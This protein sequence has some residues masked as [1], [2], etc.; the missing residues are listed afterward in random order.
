MTEVSELTPTDFFPPSSPDSPGYDDSKNAQ[1]REL[2]A[3]AS[4]DSPIFAALPPSVHIIKPTTQV[5]G[6][7]TIIRDK[8]TSR[9]EF[10]FYSERLMCLLIEVRNAVDWLADGDRSYAGSVQ[11]AMNFVPYVSVEVET[12]T[13]QRYK[14]CRKC[15]NICG[16]VGNS[17]DEPVAHTARAAT[18]PDF[19]P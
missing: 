6:L 3:R 7:H 11:E 13:G 10:I 9:D 4:I 16:V 14:G 18:W 1:Q 17:S 8:R 15:G 5:Q 19:R 12:P 2:L